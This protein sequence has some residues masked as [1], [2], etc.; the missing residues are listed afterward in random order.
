ME[1]EDAE[2]EEK[3]SRWQI[4]PSVLVVLQQVYTMD[5]FPSTDV[6]KQLAMKLKAHPRQIQ[7]W[8]QNRRAR[9]RRLGGTVHRPPASPL[10]PGQTFAGQSAAVAG[11]SSE[12]G[13]HH[14]QACPVQRALRQC[15][16]ALSL[17]RTHVPWPTR[18]IRVL[19]FHS[20]K[21]R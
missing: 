15:L 19:L 20:F 3:I 13:V 12:T 21:E 2:D 5:P 6:R 7:T 10:V 8:F 11:P 16:P 18:N 4:S 17:R 1:A 9:E 14:Q